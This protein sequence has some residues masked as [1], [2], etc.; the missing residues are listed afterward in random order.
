MTDALIAGPLASKLSSPIL[1]N[2]T[3]YV[4]SYHEDNSG[5]KTVVIDLGHGGADLLTSIHYNASNTQGNGVEVYYK[6]E[7]ANGGTSKT[8]ATN[9][10]NSILEKF[11]LKNRGIKTRVT[12]TV[13]DYYHIIRESKAPS[14]IV[15]C[16]F[17]DNEEN[18]KLVN[19]L[20]KIQLMGT[21]I[22]KGIENTVK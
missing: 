11:S 9:I 8:L 13:A 10:L 21:Q 7:D 15:E 2:P 18:Q 1:I 16:S 12:S 20:V 22:G 5:T 4:S 14:A 19:T 6:S 3:S 17:I